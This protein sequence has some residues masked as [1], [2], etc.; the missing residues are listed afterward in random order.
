MTLADLVRRIGEL[1]EAAPPP[2]TAAPARDPAIAKLVTAVA[3]GYS[4]PRH[5]STER[6]KLLLD[7]LLIMGRDAAEDAAIVADD[8]PSLS[9][10][11][12]QRQLDDRMRLPRCRSKPEASKRLQNALN[13][14]LR[15]ADHRVAAVCAAFSLSLQPGRT[16][17]RKA[18]DSKKGG[19]SLE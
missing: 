10:D 14:T 2:G 1:I 19:T 4:A 17:P 13:L 11:T 18:R 3:A 6:R 8:Y 9:P 15:T 16:G 12:L 7:Y 5:R